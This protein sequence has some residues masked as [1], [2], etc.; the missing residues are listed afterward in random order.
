[1]KTPKANRDEIRENALTIPMSKE[2]KEAV[3]KAA[4]DMGVT[5]SAFA[6][7]VL[8]DF[9]KKGKEQRWQ[10]YVCYMGRVEQE[11]PQV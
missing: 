5:M 11:N 6:R 3:K 7:I 2:E 8:K 1:M 9:M 4:D 10:F